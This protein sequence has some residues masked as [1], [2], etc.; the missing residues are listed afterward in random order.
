MHFV[1]QEKRRKGLEYETLFLEF[2]LPAGSA[3]FWPVDSAGGGA[4]DGPYGII[5][6]VGLSGSPVDRCH[7]EEGP[8]QRRTFPP[9]VRRAAS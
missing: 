1:F 3:G 5:C 9:P 6:S 8:D 2:A 7:H 4:G